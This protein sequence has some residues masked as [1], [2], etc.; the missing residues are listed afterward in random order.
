M[1]NK[2]KNEKY[3]YYIKEAKLNNI[4]NEEEEKELLN[5]YTFNYKIINKEL[6]KHYKIYLENKERSER[7]KIKKQ[8]EYTDKINKKFI[9]QLIKKQKSYRNATLKKKLKLIKDYDLIYNKLSSYYKDFISINI[10]IPIPNFTFN[11]ELILL[12]ID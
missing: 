8:L 5:E 10:D 7:L 2:E 3:I 1:N 11:N 12:S 4:I 6:D 9:K